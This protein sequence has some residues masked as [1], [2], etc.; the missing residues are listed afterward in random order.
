M[1]STHQSGLS[2][3]CLLFH[4]WLYWACP[5]AN[6][7]A[8]ADADA[9]NADALAKGRPGEAERTIQ[10]LRGPKTVAVRGFF[11]GLAA[12]R[13]RHAAASRLLGGRELELDEALH[14]DS[15]GG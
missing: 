4:S 14:A 12:T 2:F 1:G 8:G 3:Q 9:D 13:T 6:A 5:D 15:F 7:G 10:L 11:T